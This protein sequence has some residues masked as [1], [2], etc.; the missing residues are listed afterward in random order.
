MS[1]FASGTLTIDVYIE[2]RRKRNE[3]NKTNTDVIEMLRSFFKL[4]SEVPLSSL[5]KEIHLKRSKLEGSRFKFYS[6]NGVPLCTDFLGTSD[7]Q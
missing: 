1:K 6:E 3:P 2:G 5:H 4:T 7:S